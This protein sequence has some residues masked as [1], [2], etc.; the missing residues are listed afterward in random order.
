[1]ETI[2][3]GVNRT[4]M[5]EITTS[6][7][8]PSATGHPPKY[9]VQVGGPD[10]GV[11]Y[12]F[13]DQIEIGRDKG[14]SP[15]TGVLLINDPTVSSRH[16]II[17]Q[18]SD[19]R[20]YVRDSSRNGTRLDGRRLSPNLKTAITI[21]QVVSLGRFLSFRLEGEAP[22]RAAQV[23]EQSTETMGVP[24]TSIVTVLVGDIRGYTNLVQQ[25]NPSLL[26]ES[27]T[28]VFKRLETT[29]VELGGTVKEFQGDAIFAYWERG[30]SPNH[31]AEACNA[32]LVLHRKVREMAADPAVWP[33]KEY[34]L[35]MDWALCTGTVVI[36][37][38]GGENALGISMVGESVVLAF[39][40]EKL[41]ED[42]TSS[43][44]VCPDTQMLAGEGFEFKD[45][46][47]KKAKGFDEPKKLFALTGEKRS[48]G[49]T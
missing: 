3:V 18:G 36:S 28:R 6:Y 49:G 8:T 34:P 22:T 13:F 2:I 45:L 12:M 1:V 19:G 41:A 4:T 42:D 20:C 23:S 17:T 14:G 26:Q 9:L 33:M 35:E 32:A 16:C 44:I 11:S 37:G 5:E 48:R 21:G 15:R 40:M 24:N 29:V 38:Y 10:D 47:S 30:P 39:R 46:G 43:I 25:V 31:A 27:V 7:S